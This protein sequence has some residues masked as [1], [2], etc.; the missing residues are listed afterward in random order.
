MNE[1]EIRV[2]EQAGR[3][4]LSVSG[5]LTFESVSQLQRTCQQLLGKIERG[6][7]IIDMAGLTYIDSLSMGRFVALNKAAMEKGKKLVLINQQ[8]PIRDAFRMLH[9]DRVIEIR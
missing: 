9:V 1:V 2:Q 3:P 5:K 6:E 7:L 8:K 4:V